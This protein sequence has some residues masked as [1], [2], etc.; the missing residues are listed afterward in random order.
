MNTPAAAPSASTFG[1]WMALTGRPAGLA[2]RRPGDG[3]VSARR[4]GRRLRESG[5]GR[6]D[7][8]TA[9]FGII[10]AFFLVGA[11]TGGVLFGWLGDR[12][13]RVRAMMLSVL[14]YAL[15]SGPV[16]VR[17]DAWQI[18]VLRFVAALGMGGEWSLGVA[19]INEIWPDRSRALLAGLIGAAAN[20]GYLIIG[21]VG[22][23]VIDNIEAT[24][25]FLAGLNLPSVWID[26][27]INESNH[28]WR[29]LMMCG[30]LP[31]LLTFFIQIFRAGVAALGKRRPEGSNFPLGEP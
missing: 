21:F 5:R 13:G 20:V 24:Q 28:G 26:Y 18:G 11:A 3:P 27:L 25:S 29:L 31:A 10:T 22:K 23:L 8:R 14:T 4:P 6:E 1:K 12:I 9:W 19:L 2:V 7:H 17:D 30:A 15:V 16:R